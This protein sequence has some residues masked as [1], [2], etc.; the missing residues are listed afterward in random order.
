M[1][2][3]HP[4]L[5][6]FWAFYCFL[7]NILNAQ[8]EPQQRFD[9]LGDTRYSK[10]NFTN[11]IVPYNGVD[12]WMELK[13]TW[14]W[15]ERQNLGIYADGLGSNM[16]YPKPPNPV[17]P[18]DWQKYL[19]GGIGLQWYPFAPKKSL[20]GNSKAKDYKLQYGIRLFAFKAWR[21]YYAKNKA[22]NPFSKYEDE[23][24]QVGFDYYYDNILNDELL[25][26]SFWSN[27]TFRATNF[28]HQQFNTFFWTGNAKIGPKWKSDNATYYWYG[29]TDWI[30]ISGCK[31]RWWENYLRA[32]SGV[33]WYPK[34]HDIFGYPSVGILR[35]FHLYVE[36]LYHIAWLKDPPTGKVNK[37]D[38]RFGIG[39][40]TPG[41]FKGSK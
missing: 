9:L 39:F 17:I 5:F 25:T 22:G 2:K 40:S 14:W 29:F 19:Q 38:I 35:R 4:G 11:L 8:P 16:F 23:D 18:F 1:P 30:Y 24:I 12:S 33:R 20:F 13:L 28:S 27:G 15:N 41:F 32:G 10:Y 34:S 36:G 3:I 21:Y 6:T 26:V 7:S 37:W 31:C